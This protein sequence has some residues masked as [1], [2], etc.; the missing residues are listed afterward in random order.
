MFRLLMHTLYA[1]T[2]AMTDVREQCVV[3]RQGIV[4]VLLS[5]I[6]NVTMYPTLQRDHD[7]A[8]V[9]ITVVL[10]TAIRSDKG[11]CSAYVG[12]CVVLVCE[13]HIGVCED[14][15]KQKQTN[16]IKQTKTN[17]NTQVGAC[18]GAQ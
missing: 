18:S 1:V 2:L 6:G 11:A 9:L 5:G 4:D 15:N 17:K 10:L 14:T 3:I 12:R 13:E 8:T 7:A 16:K